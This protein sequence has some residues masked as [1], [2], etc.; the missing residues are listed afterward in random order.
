MLFRSL[1]YAEDGLGSIAVGCRLLGC[2]I[3]TFPAVV[4]CGRRWPGKRVERVD[5]LIGD[6]AGG[7]S[8]GELFTCGRVRRA[9]QL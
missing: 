7:V 9:T 1:E 4:G 5:E 8:D 6:V 2:L 3:G